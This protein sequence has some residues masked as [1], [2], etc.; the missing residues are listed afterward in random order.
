MA[1]D[2]KKKDFQNPNIFLIDFK[3]HNR[4]EKILR[5]PVYKSF[6]RFIEKWSLYFIIHTSIKKKN[7]YIIVITVEHR[8]ERAM[9]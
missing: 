1:K 9:Y 2:Q 5:L 6:K 3:N 4:F 7:I 8:L